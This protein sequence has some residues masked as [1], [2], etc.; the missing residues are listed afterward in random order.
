MPTTSPTAYPLP[1]FTTEA[2]VIAPEDAVMFNVRP[3]PLPIM[4]YVET[5]VSDT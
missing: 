2:A 3:D 4:L 5:L 1:G